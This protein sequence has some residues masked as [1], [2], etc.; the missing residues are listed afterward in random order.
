MYNLSFSDFIMAPLV[1][2]G[3]NLGQRHRHFNSLVKKAIAEQTALEPINYDDPDVDNLL[4]IDVAC[5]N[6][7]VDYILQVFS[8]YDMLY[9]SRAIK[10]STW[11]ITE[12]QY[13]HI[14]NPKYL[15]DVLFPKMTSKAKSK[16]MLNIRLH[17]RDAQRVEAFYESFADDIK[18]A[19][20]WLPYCSSEFIE[21]IIQKHARDIKPQTLKRLCEVSFNHLKVYTKAENTGYYRR[22]NLKSTMFLLNDH[23]EEYLDVI[24][25]LNEYEIPK[26]GSKATE[27][28][29]RKCHD[30]IVERFE[31]YASNIDL[32]TFAKHL[33]KDAIEG[34]LLKQSENGKMKYWVKFENIKHF[35]KYLPI[36]NRFEFVK[37]LFIDKDKSQ[38]A[39]PYGGDGMEYDCIEVERC[40]QMCSTKMLSSNAISV[41]NAH[42]YR[43]YRFAPF[44]SA[45]VDLKKLIRVESN[46][47]ERNAMLTV[48]LHCT[49]R[50]PQHIQTI[51][52]YYR[53]K[54][55]NEP[56]KF[57]VQFVNTFISL[58]AIHK[59]DEKTW[60]MLNDIF[61]S[62]E[63]YTESDNSVPFCIKA[64]IVYKLLH[65]Q[66]IPE[67]VEKKH[68]FNTFKDY[69]KKL[70]EKEQNTLFTYLYDREMKKLNLEISNEA[71]MFSAVDTIHRVLSLVVDWKRKVENYPKIFETIKYLLTLKKEKSWKT[72]LSYMYYEQ[73]VLRRHLFEQSLALY[74][75]DEV[76]VNALKHDPG[77]FD[78][79]DA[80]VAAMRSND[81]ISLKNALGKLR[82]YWAHSLA[83]KWAKAY[84]D[85]L[86]MPTGHKATINGIC[87]LLPR[88]QCFNLLAKYAPADTK[89]NWSDTD[90]VLLSIRKNIAKRMQFVRPS[91]NL[92]EVL[93]YAKEDYLQYALPSL[94]A[95]LYNMSSADTSLCIQ[96]LV[97]APVSLQKHGIRQAFN[98][99]PLSEIQQLVNNIWNNSTNSSIK[100]VLFKQTYDLLCKEKKES[101]IKEI[102]ELLS[103]FIDKL[104]QEENR[105]IYVTL[106]KIKNVPL[107]VRPQCFVK[108]YLYLVSLP[109]KANCDSIVKSIESHAVDF[110]ELFD[111]TFVEDVLLKSI[112]A[113]MTET[114]VY[115]QLMTKLKIMSSYILTVKDEETQYQRYEKVMRPFLANCF[116]S[117]GLKKQKQYVVRNNCK[118]LLEQLL[119]SIKVH[120]LKTSVVSVK[121]FKDIQA[122]IV[123]ALAPE[124]NYALLSFWNI[125][126]SFVETVASYLKDLPAKSGPVESTGNLEQDAMLE[127]PTPRE[128]CE[129][130]NKKEWENVCNKIAPQFGEACLNYLKTDIV[131]K[132]PSIFTIFARSLCDVF[133]TVDFECKHRLQTFKPMLADSDLIVSYLVV[134]EALR[135]TYSF[136]TKHIKD[137][138]KTIQNIIKSHPST[139]VKIHY[140]EYEIC[141]SDDISMGED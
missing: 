70:N 68:S 118:A 96:R 136:D 115:G 9:V 62:M 139:E 12:D 131:L 1:L 109:P 67:I 57:K 20:K 32:P 11:L 33:K 116:K 56:F 94:N 10:Q 89:I 44:E 6:R 128:G 19:Q 35:V 84:Q 38:Y 53:E 111:P 69:Y 112:D 103:S 80:E 25:P 41:S 21:N 124:E 47:A 58:N 66:A 85:Q 23:T 78:R 110:I 24:E 117:W 4:K 135:S 52:Q 54:H 132:V 31:K 92:E 65:N 55:I 73:K 77:L 133:S 76:C 91:P 114:N 97:N 113:L 120:S 8:S 13:A 105:L 100:T 107:I 50:N 71:E 43:W 86:D 125:T 79:Y 141:N 121:M 46:P 48:L 104:T 37:K 90:E 106:G 29:M 75:T 59:F 137:L 39:T 81:T 40:V 27:V 83:Q 102:W 130:Q 99:L 15:K 134:L 28:I 98:K 63:V 3:E 26:F 119:T 93:T 61:T 72:D 138:K 101:N 129:K 14:V 140:Y 42:I 2:E 30:R 122:N 16:F 95:I 45:F 64:I 74:P 82:I 87:I 127:C 36:E 18:T 49:R 126:V 5:N 60:G 17:L 34:F 7:D 51:L 123:T 88:T 108:S 22:D